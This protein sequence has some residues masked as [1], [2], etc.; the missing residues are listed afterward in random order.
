MAPGFGRGLFRVL[1]WFSPRKMRLL[2]RFLGEIPKPGYPSLV[3]DTSEVR[4]EF[5]L[6]D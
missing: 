2:P 4:T 3:S 5:S 1:D 6:H